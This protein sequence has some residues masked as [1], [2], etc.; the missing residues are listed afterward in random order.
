M[1]AQVCHPPSLARQGGQHDP[2]AR[3]DPIPERVHQSDFVLHL[4]EG[5]WPMASGPSTTMLD[6]LNETAGGAAP[7][8][9]GL[10]EGL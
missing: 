4:T 10:A 8:G 9:G 5:A 2:A 3:P 6:A 1:T 7:G